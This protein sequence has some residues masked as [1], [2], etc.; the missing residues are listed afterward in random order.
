MNYVIIT[1]AYNEEESIRYILESVLKQSIKPTEWI[2]VNDGSTDSTADIVSNY[3]QNYDWIKL[4]NKKREEIEFGKHAVINF[5]FGM[6]YLTDDRYDYIVKLDADLDIDRKDYFEYQLEQFK[7]DP[8]LGIASGIT[9][10]Y[11]EDGVKKY[12]WHPEWRT[13]GALKMYR[14]DCLKDINGLSPIYGWDGLDEYKAMFRG[15]ITKTFYNLEVKHLEKKRDIE[16]LKNP[17]F[18]YARGKSYYQ[19]GFPLFFVMLKT[20]NYFLKRKIKTGY[21]FLKGYVVSMNNNTEQFVTNEEKRFIRRFQYKK[22]VLIIGDKL[23]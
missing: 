8:K 6:N 19:R 1:S 2:I 16:R 11:N 10:Y 13:T 14:K 20:V 3:C 7:K 18:H 15:W 4:I 22:L 9:Y 21:N 5:N 12:G 23:H 17:K